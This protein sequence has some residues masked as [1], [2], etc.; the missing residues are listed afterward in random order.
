MTTIADN[1]IIIYVQSVYTSANNAPRWRN[2]PCSHDVI[3]C[4]TRYR[5]RPGTVNGAKVA[6]RVKKNTNSVRGGVNGGER[7]EGLFGGSETRRTQYTVSDNINNNACQ[8]NKTRSIMRSSNAH[9]YCNFF[10]T[11]TIQ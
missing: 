2:K 4:S 5:A 1:L 7:G 6:E 3:D 10:C 11:H 8:Y 9:Y